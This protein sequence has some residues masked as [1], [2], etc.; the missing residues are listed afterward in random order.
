MPHPKSTWER[1][2]AMHLRLDRIQ[3]EQAETSERLREVRA[4]LVD[5]ARRLAAINA[6]LQ[7]G[8]PVA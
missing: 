8:L 6:A 4:R 2:L 5:H 1:T 3:R 7:A